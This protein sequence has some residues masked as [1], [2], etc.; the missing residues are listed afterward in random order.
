MGEI[1]IRE[2]TGTGLVPQTFRLRYEIYSEDTTPSVQSRALGMMTDLHDD[3]ARHWA[4]F[5]GDTL[6]AS[7]R[8]CIHNLQEEIPD[9]LN[10]QEVEL[11]TPI[12][13]INRLVVK[14]NW[15]TRGLAR[16]FD[17]CRIQAAR[18]S[19]AACVVGSAFEW[20]IAP[21]QECG[22][23]LI[24]DRWTTRGMILTL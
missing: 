2:I 16:Q 1:E 18:A 10:F 19:H 12:A 7:A 21:L 11:P 24:D 9:E 4:A 17:L 22:F 5:D 6:V 14:R 15:R 8:M 23:T 3:H 13:T 20:R